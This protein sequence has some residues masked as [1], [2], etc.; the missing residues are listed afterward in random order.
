MRGPKSHEL[1]QM[2]LLSATLISLALAA[3]LDG[4]NDGPS[5]NS[6][7]VKVFEEKVASVL[8]PSTLLLLGLTSKHF[9][10]MC[11]NSFEALYTPSESAPKTINVETLYDIYN[12]AGPVYPD[13]RSYLKKLV[14]KYLPL[15]RDQKYERI[16]NAYKEALFNNEKLNC[17]ITVTKRFPELC[18]MI[19][20]YKKF[21]E[22]WACSEIRMQ[23]LKSFVIDLGLDFIQRSSWLDFEFSDVKKLEPKSAIILCDFMNDKGL[24]CRNES[25]AFYV[26][27]L[28]ARGNEIDQFQERMPERLSKTFR[29]HFFSIIKFADSRIISSVWKAMGSN[30][31]LKEPYIRCVVIWHALNRCSSDTYTT[32]RGSEFVESVKKIF[33]EVEKNENYALP[34]N[35]NLNHVVEVGLMLGAPEEAVLKILKC[36]QTSLIPYLALIANIKMAQNS[37]LYAIMERTVGEKHGKDGSKFLSIVKSPGFH[38]NPF[39]FTHLLC[40]KR[41][42]STRFLSLWN[43]AS[44]ESRGAKILHLLPNSIQTRLAQELASCDSFPKGLVKTLDPVENLVQG[45][46]WAA[47]LGVSLNLVN[48]GFECSHLL[49]YLDSR[50]DL[51]ELLSK[52]PNCI[53][54]SLAS[55][56][57]S[58]SSTKAFIFSIYKRE[59]GIDLLDK[60]F[61]DRQFYYTI[62]FAFQHPDLSISEMVDHMP[63]FTNIGKFFSTI[64]VFS[65]KS[66]LSQYEA[67]INELYREIGR[68]IDDQRYLK[69]VAFTYAA[70]ILNDYYPSEHPLYRYVKHD[71]LKQ[72]IKWFPECYKTVEKDLRAAGSVDSMWTRCNEGEWS[73]YFGV[74]NMPPHILDTIIENGHYH[75]ADGLLRTM[76]EAIGMSHLTREDV[77]ARIKQLGMPLVIPRA[78]HP[79]PDFQ[80]YGG[81]SDSDSDTSCETNQV[82][83]TNIAGLSIPNLSLTSDNGHSVFAMDDDEE[84]DS[85][86]MVTKSRFFLQ[87]YEAILS[88]NA[89]GDDF[90]N[91]NVESDSEC[92]EMSYS[93]SGDYLRSSSD[94]RS[95]STSSWGSGDDKP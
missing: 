90:F 6:L 50:I 69:I 43:L 41:E 9:C 54:E 51:D 24:Q 33:L 32:I 93:S 36:D 12:G 86:N 3:Y 63:E 94:G 60:H 64:D 2:R 30:W 79:V 57:S 44:K 91:E 40:L 23:V 68:R 88:D 4:M 61:T 47:G 25:L 70:Q 59:D 22:S 85:K 77:E 28:R 29:R 37:L 66:Q 75:N 19:L 18:R 53:N 65:Y 14:L 11:R 42:P 7:T 17:P 35:I 26:F 76:S 52:I 84:N 95:V 1:N 49:E 38:L 92:Q 8:C 89:N 83:S 48:T 87:A 34:E 31:T 16:Y 73:C 78:S 13:N 56:C 80:R 62:L 10:L 67:Q 72:I 46:L 81:L 21:Q 39:L 71:H 27:C 20:K 5:I 82:E 45:A 55:F 58:Q 15:P 74:H